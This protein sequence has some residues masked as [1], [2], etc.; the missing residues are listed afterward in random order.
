[1]APM[2]LQAERLSLG[3]CLVDMSFLRKAAKEQCGSMEV[4]SDAEI[5]V[6]VV[7]GESTALVYEWGIQDSWKPIRFTKAKLQ[8]LSYADV[9]MHKLSKSRTRVRLQPDVLQLQTGSQ[10]WDVQASRKASTCW[11]TGA[12]AKQVLPAGFQDVEDF[13]GVHEMVLKH[14]M[15]KVG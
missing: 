1:M 3:P 13:M 5:T 11:H 9:S 12:M 10:S 6:K 2:A 15:D 4:P 8:V 14:S 7:K